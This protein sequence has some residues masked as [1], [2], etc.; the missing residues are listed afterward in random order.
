VSDK[1]SNIYIESFERRLTRISPADYSHNAPLPSPWKDYSLVLPTGDPSERWKNVHET[2]DSWTW[3]HGPVA[4]LERENNYQTLSVV[5]PLDWVIGISSC[6]IPVF[7]EVSVPWHTRLASAELYFHW[8]HSSLAVVIGQ[9]F[10]MRFRGL[11]RMHFAK[12]CC[13]V[14]GICIMDPNSNCLPC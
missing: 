10:D 11:A 1:H 12:I 9:H 3:L 4:A 2:P 14:H 6:W 8:H 5:G 13:R 7:H